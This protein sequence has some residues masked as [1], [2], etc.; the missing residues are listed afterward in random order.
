MEQI[1]KALEVGTVKLVG[2]DKQAIIR[3]VLTLIN[4]YTNGS[5]KQPLWRRIGLF[6]DH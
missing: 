6:K 1:G 4:V 2:T 5:G 3:E